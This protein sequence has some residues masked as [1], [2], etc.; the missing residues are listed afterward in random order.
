MLFMHI[1]RHNK[2]LLWLDNL[3]NLKQ[4][5]RVNQSFF[6]IKTKNYIV[7]KS[8]AVRPLNFPILKLSDYIYYKSIGDV[9]YT[10]FKKSIKLAFL[11]HFL[12]FKDLQ[13]DSYSHLSWHQ[14]RLWANIPNI[15]YTWH[16]FYY[17]YKHMLSQRYRRYVTKR[18]LMSKNDPIFREIYWEIYYHKMRRTGIKVPDDL[19]YYSMSDQDDYVKDLTNIRKNEGY[20]QFHHSLWKIDVF[21]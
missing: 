13:L 6:T 5:K 14:Q 7:D 1:L 21:R 12:I 20:D 3:K 16:K 17:I 4:Y 18:T 15:Y 8:E 19:P 11:S 2:Y 10:F 9:Y